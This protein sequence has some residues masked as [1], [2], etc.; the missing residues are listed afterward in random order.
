VS[1]NEV[2]DSHDGAARKNESPLQSFRALI[3]ANGHRP[4]RGPAHRRQHRQAAGALAAK[5][6]RR[7]SKEIGARIV[8]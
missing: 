6:V 2:G 8:L 1:R 3:I 5:G 7:L 4:R